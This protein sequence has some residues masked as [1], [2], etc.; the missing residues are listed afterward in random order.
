[1]F[2]LL[3][4]AQKQKKLV[5]VFTDCDD[6]GSFSLGYV[7]AVEGDLL[8]LSTLSRTGQNSGVEIIQISS[9]S[10]IE[11]DGHYEKKIAFLAKNTK[12]LPTPVAPIHKA[13]ELSIQSELKYLFES[14]A[15]CE[16]TGQDNDDCMVGF[17]TDVNDSTANI[18][19]IDRYGSADGFAT[20][21]ID[22]IE[23]IQFGTQELLIRQ[24]LFENQAMNIPEP[25]TDSVPPLP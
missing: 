10:K 22:G 2:D 7:V 6:W 24:F 18:R 8:K 20:I 3:K 13:H 9:I 19:L 4:K 11:Y 17:L 1:M 5:S 16:I 12:Q 15:Y 25:T 21:H 14:G 23:S